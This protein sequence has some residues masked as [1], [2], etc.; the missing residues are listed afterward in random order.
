MFLDSEEAE[1]FESEDLEGTESEPEE[2]GCLPDLLES[3]D[4]ELSDLIESDESEILD[5]ESEETG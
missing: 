1:L 3:R 5:F 4:F 2:T